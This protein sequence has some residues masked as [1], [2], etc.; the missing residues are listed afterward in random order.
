MLKKNSRITLAV[1]LV[2]ATV[3]IAGGVS[4]ASNT[5]FKINKPLPTTLAGSP[6]VGNNW[7][8][9]PFFHPY[10][11]GQV[12]CQQLG[13]RQTP[14]QAT[15]AKLDPATGIQTPGALCGA[16]AAGFTW[17]AGQGVLIRNTAGA[18][19]PTSVIIVG[20]HNPATTLTLPA[21]GTGATANIGNMWLAVPYHTTAVT[22]Q[23][24][25]NQI[26]LVSTG[27]I[28]VRG[29]LLRQNAAT[30]ASTPGIC[31]S[32]ASTITLVLGEA[33]RIRQPAPGA[34]LTFTPAHF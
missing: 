28:G 1:V 14:P 29:S 9:L 16:A 10:T 19:A 26:G 20:S 32:T 21:A 15:L 13:L 7:T 33:I 8:S 34:P 23:D 6:N 17:S 3:L 18:G 24:L 5:G 30:G 12:L 22:G 27:A 25:C 11:N 4:I 2:A 31:G